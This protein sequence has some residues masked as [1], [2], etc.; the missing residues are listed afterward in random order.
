MLLQGE[1][2]VT[3]AAEMD[4]IEPRFD[5]F[6]GV[7]SVAKRTS[8]RRGIWHSSSLQVMGFMKLLGQTRRSGSFKKSET[9]R[10]RS[11]REPNDQAHAP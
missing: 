7:L 10:H 3:I 5:G 6:L 2:L 9:E 11:A 1:R 8:R 4:L